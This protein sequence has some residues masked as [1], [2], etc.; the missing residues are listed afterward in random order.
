M[1]PLELKYYYIDTRYFQS[2]K[3]YHNPRLIASSS[4]VRQNSS[5]GQP[6]RLRCPSS[7]LRI[8]IISATL[9]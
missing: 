3:D 7:A 4:V 9:I 6:P 5:C 1:Q 8:T 2:S